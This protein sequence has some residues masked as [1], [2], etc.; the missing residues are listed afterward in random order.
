MFAPSDSTPVTAFVK[1]DRER[2][3]HKQPG[4]AEEFVIYLFLKYQ[5]GNWPS[6]ACENSF[7]TF[8]W[9]QERRSLFP[10]IIQSVDIS[11]EASAVL[12]P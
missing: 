1:P 9:I 12:L 4:P 5:L 3:R 2:L 6:Q 10:E 7:R 11:L 8:L